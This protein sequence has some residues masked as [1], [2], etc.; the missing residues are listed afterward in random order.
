MS[1]AERA[2]VCASSGARPERTRALVAARRCRAAA[3]S[4]H[5]Q[6]K[7]HRVRA[8]TLDAA[9]EASGSDSC[10]PSGGDI[11]MRAPSFVPPASLLLSIL[12]N[13]TTLCA[14]GA[15]NEAHER[16]GQHQRTQTRTTA[17]REAAAAA[18]AAK[19][20]VPPKQAHHGGGGRSIAGHCFGSRRRR[21]LTLIGRPLA[22]QSVGRRCW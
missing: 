3:A 22:G 2:S 5:A 11:Q 19:L 15:D 1:T 12:A 20:S 21:R 6:Q 7:L 16:L 8:R 10:A 17:A 14:C 18:A 9:A 4:G 13:T